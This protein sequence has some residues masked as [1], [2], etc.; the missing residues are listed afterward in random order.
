MRETLYA[1]DII[2]VYCNFNINGEKD[3][4]MHFEIMSKGIKRFFATQSLLLNMLG[5][6]ETYVLYQKKS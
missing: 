4:N 6:Y 3:G 5:I 1:F 2:H